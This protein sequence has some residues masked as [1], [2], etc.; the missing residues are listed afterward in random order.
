MDRSTFEI[1]SVVSCRLIL[2]WFLGC[3]YGLSCTSH[4][5]QKID[6]RNA[7]TYPFLNALSWYSS[8]WQSSKQSGG[9][10][11]GMEEAGGPRE[12]WRREVPARVQTVEGAKSPGSKRRF[13]RQTRPRWRGAASDA[14]P[15]GT[16]EKSSMAKRAACPRPT[17]RRRRTTGFGLSIRIQR[18]PWRC[19]RLSKN[20]LSGQRR[21]RKRR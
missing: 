14:I 10:L 20:V 18:R 13:V 2:S 9:G 12:S 21:P 1:G 7:L 17:A 11:Q 4:L 15:M 19:W 6:F 16:T 3:C 5:G 8:K